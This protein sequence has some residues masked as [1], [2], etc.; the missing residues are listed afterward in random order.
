MF[1]N[2]KR[3]VNRKRMREGLLERAKITPEGLFKD[4]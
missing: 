3:E 2:Q 4:R 1:E